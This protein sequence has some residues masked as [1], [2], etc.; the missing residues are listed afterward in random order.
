LLGGKLARFGAIWRSVLADVESARMK[1][2]GDEIEET[3][4]EARQGVNVAGMTSVLFVSLGLA[5][6]I[7]AALWFFFMR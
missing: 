4:Q 7:L 6:V 5:V 1:K 3:A 2:D